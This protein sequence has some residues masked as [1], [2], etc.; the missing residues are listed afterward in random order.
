M[1]AM[2]FLTKQLKALPNTPGVY[3][4]KDAKNQTLYVGKAKNLRPRVQ[5]YFRPAADLEES[6]Q[7]RKSATRSRG[8]QMVPSK[9]LEP[10]KQQMVQRIAR[11]ET[12]STDNETEALVLEAN[13]IRQHQPPYNVVLRDDKYY[14]FIKITREELPRVFITRR[15]KQDKARYFGPY[16]SARSVRAT[17]RLLRRIFP[18]RGEKDLP[19]EVIFPHPLFDPN[20]AH[21]KNYN[22]EPITYNL[23]IQNIIKFLQGKRDDIMSTLK[24]GME[25]A[26]Q[27]AH[28]EQAAIFRDQLQ[29]L[30][31]LE[32]SQKVYLP[33]NESFD[34]VSI[35]RERSR[36]AANVFQI[37]SGKLLGKQTFLL[38]HRSTASAADTLRQFLLQYY[39]VAQDIPKTIF[40]PLHLEDEEALAQWVRPDAP[41]V[42][43]VP[44]RGK[45]RQL[46]AMGE[47]NAQQLLEEQ[48]ADFENAERTRAAHR[49][50]ITALGLNPNTTHR[51]ET[52]DISNIQGQLATASMVVFTD[53]EAQR[54]QYRKFKMHLEGTPNDP[55]KSLQGEDHGASFALQKP[56]DYAMIRQTLYR[57]FSGH[58][59]DW[60]MPDLIVID[61][62]KGQ[63]SSAKKVLDEL[64]VDLPL[65]AIAKREEEIFLVG[66]P[67][68]IRLAYDSAALHL[69]QRMRDEAHRFT[70]TYHRLL[71]SRRQQRSILDEVP[72]IGPKTKKQLLA[73]FGSLKNIRAASV[74][75]LALLI[76]RSKAETLKDFL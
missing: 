26:S 10:S 72:G 57:R 51:L 28:Y 75:E 50:L 43:T 56:D 22:L 38:N 76:G 73:R 37:R 11:I 35:A 70:I 3:L 47:T 25:Q 27:E 45:K 65:I 6:K 24:A 13:L 4:F 58:Q 46:L 64:N 60:P 21:Q 17:L 69:I 39:S 12:I 54:N 41:P 7:P 32:G 31:R 20:R 74:D 62:G 1:G 68:P 8:K 53:G 52:Y 23:N 19:R 15:I 14:L 61:G 5:S 66:K 63:L 40:I 36:S 34:M 33:N 48:A 30:E 18:F 42:W 67:E 55:V 59:K 49:E 29:A 16:S 71:R 2:E 9:H 44:A